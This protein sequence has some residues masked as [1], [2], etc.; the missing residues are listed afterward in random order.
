MCERY[1]A[2]FGPLAFDT[3]LGV[4]PNIIEPCWPINGLRHW[5][6]AEFDSNLLKIQ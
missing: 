3:K 1:C 6:D 4:K 5:R 2:L